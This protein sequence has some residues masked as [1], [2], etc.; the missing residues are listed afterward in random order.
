MILK[1]SYHESD[2]I[3]RNFMTISMKFTC[4]VFNSLKLLSTTMIHRIV[5]LPVSAFLHSLS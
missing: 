3:I 1:S 4:E 5:A 2:L